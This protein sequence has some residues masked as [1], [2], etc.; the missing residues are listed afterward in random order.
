VAL[1]AALGRLLDDVDLRVRL[2]ARARRLIE[3]RFDVDHNVAGWR[4]VVLTEVPDA[5]RVRVR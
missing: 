1:A 5:R 3:Q 4:D 2:S